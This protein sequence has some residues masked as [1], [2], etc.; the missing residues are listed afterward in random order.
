MN[1]T[2][3]ASIVSAVLSFG[4]AWNLQQGRF[5]HAEKQR[6]EI[7]AESQRFVHAAEQ[8][9]SSRVITAQDNSRKRAITRSVELGSAHSAGNGLRLAVD[10]AVRTAQTNPDACPGQAVTLAVVF[11]ECKSALLEMGKDADE[12]FSEYQLMRDASGQD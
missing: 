8:A 2:I 12:W 1:L 3:I 5:D 4:V 9:R 11:G 10:T 7:A 6:L